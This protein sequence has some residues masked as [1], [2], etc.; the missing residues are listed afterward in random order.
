MKK[1]ALFS[2]TDKTGCVEF[3][4]RLADLGY[5]IVSTGGTA[6]VLR[7]GGLTVLDV[8]DVTGYPECLDGRVK[9][10]H[11]NIHAG[12]LALRENPEHMATL[13][14]LN[15]N[16][17][18]L[19]AVN[20]YPFKATVTKPGVT[21]EDAIE[22][23]DIGGPSMLRAA[24]KN[25][26]G[27]VVVCDP[28]DYDRIAEGL[29]QGTLTREDQ[30]RL[31]YKT[32]NH[33]ANYD[34]MISTWLRETLEEDPFP[35]TLTVTYE[36]VQSMRYG[37]NP[38]QKAAFYKEPFATAGTLSE[39]RQLH[40]KELSFNNINDTAAALDLLK[41]FGTE[42]PAAVGLKHTNAC[43]V[44]TGA[45]L[46]EA[47]TRAYDAD[48]VSIFGG[49]VAVNREVDE[50]TAK[51]MS[52]IFLEI[53]IAPSFSEEALAV[54]TAKKYL[55]LLTLDGI[56]DAYQPGR[57]DMKKIAGG[58]LV[59]DQNIG[60]YNRDELKCVT[61][62]QPTEE[63]M[64]ALDFAWRV[65]KHTKS[66]AIVL[67][68]HDGKYLSTTGVGPGQTNRITAL[69][70]AARYAGEKAKGSVLA[71]DAF[72]PFDDC[73]KAAAEAGITAIIQ[74]GGSIR[75]EDSIRAC[76]EAGIAMVFCGMRHFKH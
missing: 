16:T 14:Q 50:A 44:G 36:R 8:S 64:A 71:S 20:L 27:V 37:E 59:Q 32:F 72:F 35:D 60:F 52:E 28:A 41:E 42:T 6:R 29:E 26:G 58:L 46:L 68:A 51:K 13:E 54:L 12:L 23:I 2:L 3:A 39:A 75:D 56:A 11:P 63:E 69:D 17:V 31:A 22:N 1:R 5:E 48:P 61:K 47:Y 57:F 10:L 65:V 15:I 24:A 38:H 45:T 7:E 67:A 21:L 76:D 53:I 4:R 55:R 43:G 74:P 25:Y 19:V 73:V 66:N 62:R 49:I 18:D 33:T 34:A 9:T 40:G 30:L 70:L